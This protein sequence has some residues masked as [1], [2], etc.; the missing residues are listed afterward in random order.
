MPGR[1][2]VG[3]LTLFTDQIIASHSDIGKE[4]Q[5]Q[6]PRNFLI[7]GFVAFEAIHNADDLQDERGQQKNS[8]HKNSF[9]GINRTIIDFLRSPA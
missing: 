8:D 3:V 7:D 9:L 4:K 5:N 1:N 6:N 2:A